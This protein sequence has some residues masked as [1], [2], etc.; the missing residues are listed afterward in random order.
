MRVASGA[1]SADFDDESKV[2]VPL[3][4]LESFLPTSP[5]LHV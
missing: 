3:K 1:E 4:D 5:S 2:L